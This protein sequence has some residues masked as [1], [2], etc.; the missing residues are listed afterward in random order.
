M[1]RF[2]GFHVGYLNGPL[3][4]EEA[5]ELTAVRKRDALA[6]AAN[7]KALGRVLW[8]TL[9]VA[10][11]LPGPPGAPPVPTLARSIWAHPKAFGCLEQVR[12]QA[13]AI[14]ADF[15]DLFT[16]FNEYLQD[17]GVEDQII[18]PDYS[19]GARHENRAAVGTQPAPFISRHGA[20]ALLPQDISEEE[21]VR[22]AQLLPHPFTAVPK[23]P[24]DLEFA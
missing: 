7:T 22:L 11:H 24:I 5:V 13:I 4:K 20:P 6:C 2:Q 12:V 10:G 21:H 15:L 14:A 16:P 19:A 17:L 3:D 18:G 1:E 9:F 8:N 23:L